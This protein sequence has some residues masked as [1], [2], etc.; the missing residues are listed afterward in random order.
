M[1]EK[2]CFGFRQDPDKQS[3]VVLTS[4]LP[5]NNKTNNL[6]FGGQWHATGRLL[7]NGMPMA[8]IKVMIRGHKAGWETTFTAYALTDSDGI[9]TFWGI[10]SGRRYMYWS[11]PG[12]Y[13][14]SQWVEIGR[15]HFE[16]GI[17]MDMGDF[18]LDLAVV[19]IKVAAENPDE[20]LNQLDVYI[21]RYDEKVFYG[22]KAGQLLPRAEPN[23]PYIFHNLAPGIYEAIA[24]RS[25]Y[26]TIHKV[27][28]IKQDQKQCDVNLWIPAGSSTLSGKI[29][30]SDPKELQ[31]PLILRSISQEVTMLI[32]PAADGSYEIGNLPAGDYIIGRASVALSRQSII[33]EVILKSGENK[34]LDIEVDRIDR[35]YGGYLVV[36]VVTEEGLPLPGAKVW[37]EKNGAI[38]EPHFDSDKSKAFA[39]DV[40]E[41]TLYAEYPSYR[42]IQQRVNIKSKE[43]LS[44]QEILKPV[45]ITMFKQ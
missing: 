28:E 39:G 15:F 17:D 13:G 3:G 44:T 10:P 30:P 36:V 43:V 29:I 8:N 2:L 34:K 24:S 6:N 5:K 31:I 1:P 21:Q 12:M 14:Q 20:S 25:G 19:V 18:N 9:F 26:P 16:S 33:K 22:S 27:F 35:E 42:K 4:I 40:G 23:D 38:T 41:Y 11:I 7:Q 32:Q 45:V 37:L